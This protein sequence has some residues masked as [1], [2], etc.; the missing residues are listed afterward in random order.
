MSGDRTTEQQIPARPVSTESVRWHHSVDVLVVG[1]GNGGLTSALCCYELGA[2]DV[3]VVEKGARYGGTSARSGGGVWIP[4]NHYALD[5]GAQDTLAEARAY[6]HA[7]IPENDRDPGLIDAYLQ[8]GPE[9]V[10]LLADRTRVRYRSLSM[11]PDYFSDAPGARPGHRSLE[12]EPFFLDQLGS[13]WQELLP[14]HP[15]MF[16]LGKISITMEEAHQFM[17]MLPGWLKT[18]ARLL[19]KYLGDFPWRL[20]TSV[21]RRVT[22]GS[23][24]IAQLR[25]SMLDRNMP[26]WLRTRLVRLIHDGDR[27]CGAVVER[28]GQQV[29]IRARR[30][31]IL[32]AGGFAKN[33]SMRD[34]YLPKPT[35]SAWSAAVDTDTG[36]AIVAAE[37]LGARLKRMHAAWWVPTFVPPDDLPRLAVIERSLPGSCVVNTL[38]RR[39][40]NEAQNYMTF[41]LAAQARHTESDPS[42]PAFFIFDAR[43]RRSYITGPLLRS[44]LRPDIVLPRSYSR[45]GFLHRAPTIEAL[46]AAAGI[47]KGTSAQ[48]PVNYEILRRLD[49]IMSVAADFHQIRPFFSYFQ[50]VSGLLPVLRAHSSP[51]S[52][53]NS[54]ARQPQIDQRKEGGQ[55]GCVLGQTLVAHLGESELALEHPKR[56]LDLRPDT[57]LGPLQRIDQTAARGILVQR[58]A[59]AGH[60]RHVPVRLWPI[61][62]DLLALFNASV[63]RISEDILFFTVQQFVCLRDVVRVGRC[64]HHRVHQP[65]VG[66]HPNVR[67]HAEEPLVSFLCLVHLRVARTRIVF[68]RGRGSDDRGVDSCSRLEKQT[69]LRQKRVDVIEEACAQA[70][71]FEQMPKTQNGALIRQAVNSHIQTSKLAVQR[72]VVE[73]LFHGRIRQTEPL[74]QEVDAQHRFHCKWRAPAFRAGCGCIRR[75]DCHQIRPRHDLLHLTQEHTLSRAPRLQLKTAHGGKAHLFHASTV[76]Y[77]ADASQVFTEVLQRFPNDTRGDHDG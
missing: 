74:L 18:T 26:L 32:A 21:D 35:S 57:R 69:A 2:R 51:A 22:C 72:H 5:A 59:L 54:F 63:A 28:D 3:L 61:R 66:I 60:H 10:R 62:L 30:A 11:Y 65:R 53:Q 36:D 4:C 31:V 75:N 37:R 64:R 7:V 43:F 48:H 34:R 17:S 44:S 73:R 15:S 20:R 27:V 58:S 29:N 40:A 45:S 70:V 9:M 23:A 39:L 55:V 33:Q 8:S 77:Q 68:R 56:M 52:L 50:P 41:V 25:A 13:D 46:A 19:R 42:Y 49:K 47:D 67:L 24:G 71:R 16:M 1:S 14:T 76:S 38:G 6:L 12:P